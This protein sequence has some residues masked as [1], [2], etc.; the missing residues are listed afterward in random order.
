MKANQYA[1]RRTVQIIKTKRASRG[2]QLCLG[3]ESVLLRLN[4]Q[5][6]VTNISWVRVGSLDVV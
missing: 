5:V 4:G 2:H 3:K 6:V 1:Q